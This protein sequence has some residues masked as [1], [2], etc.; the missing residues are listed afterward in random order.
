VKKTYLRVASREQKITQPSFSLSLSAFAWLPLGEKKRFSGGDSYGSYDPGVILPPD[1]Y[2]SVNQK[3]GVTLSRPL[4]KGL[5]LGRDLCAR[6][7]QAA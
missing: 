7:G 2:D 1:A 6:P 4:I 3:K 5:S